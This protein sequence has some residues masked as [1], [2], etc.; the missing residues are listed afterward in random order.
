MVLAGDAGLVICIGQLGKAGVSGQGK[1][2]V[3]GGSDSV[4][5]R[6]F[7]PKKKKIKSREYDNFIKL[8]KQMLG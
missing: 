3:S 4:F 6:R 8:L 7:L 1:R 2:C 5:S